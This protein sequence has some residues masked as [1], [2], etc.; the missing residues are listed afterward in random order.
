MAT[1]LVNTQAAAFEAGRKL[2]TEPSGVAASTP[3]RN[4][5]NRL[6][7][8]AASRG[9]EVGGSVR[10]Y[11]V[12][13]VAAL[14]RIVTARPFPVAACAIATGA[15]LGALLPRSPLERRLL[16]RV[17][18]GANLLANKLA[19]RAVVAARH[20]AEVVRDRAISKVGEAV[21]EQVLPAEL[22]HS[23]SA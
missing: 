14:G 21:L 2:T 6:W 8:V 17:G 3:I 12:H 13:G 7:R 18:Q 5:A 4:R 16:R 20:R 9:A 22:V 19:N 10:R 23:P 15:T 11:P 1:K